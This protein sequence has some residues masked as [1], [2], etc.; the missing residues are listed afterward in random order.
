DG[1]GF[2]LFRGDVLADQIRERAALEV[3]KPLFTDPGVLTIGYDVK[4][5]WQI[6]ALRR[7]EIGAYDDVMLM[8]YA[9]DAGRASQALP[10]LAEHTFNHAAI[11]LNALIKPG[12][13][14][15]TFDSFAIERAAD[16]TAARADIV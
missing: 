11:D 5:A 8:S 6:F 15:I 12:K 16:Y 3:L 4:F 1:E 14:K 7:V 9:L 2:G 10:S 13:T